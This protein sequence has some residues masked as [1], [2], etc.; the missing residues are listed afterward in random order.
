MRLLIGAIATGII[1]AFLLMSLGEEMTIYTDF[2]TAAQNP[3]KTYHVV[4]E[5]V[6]R[7]QSYYDP[8]RDIFYF[9][10]KD[11]LG[12]VR[13]VIYPDP[14]PINFEAAQRVVLIG[15]YQDTAFFAEKILMKCPSKYKEGATSSPSAS[16]SLP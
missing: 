12:I 4:A 1:L 5:W 14:K 16:L 6:E 15:K 10:A 2:Q 11:S 3:S 7:E 8:R 9:K 13:P